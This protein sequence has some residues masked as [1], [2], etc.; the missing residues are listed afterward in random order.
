MHGHGNRLCHN[1]TADS[2]TQMQEAGSSSST[3]HT[4]QPGVVLVPGSHHSLHAAAAAAAAAA[5]VV[6]LAGDQQD[7]DVCSVVEGHIEGLVG[8]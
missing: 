4:S 3:C 5:A 1:G 2:R 6:E 8:S 7:A